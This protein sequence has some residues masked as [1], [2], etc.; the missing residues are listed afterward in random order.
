METEFTD[1]EESCFY[2][3]SDSEEVEEEE[4]DDMF[5]DDEFA[6]V[7]VS[8]RRENQDKDP[9]WINTYVVNQMCLNHGLPILS[10]EQGDAARGKNP[11]VLGRGAFGCAYL[12]QEEG[13]VVKTLFYSLDLPGLLIEAKAMMLLQD[14][15]CVQQLVGICPEQ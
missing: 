10:P 8:A 2:I 14:I 6:Q 12:N 13:L 11:K 15:P 5:L 7:E 9:D 4:K 3:L 1:Q